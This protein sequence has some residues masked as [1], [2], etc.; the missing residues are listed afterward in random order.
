MSLSRKL[1]SPR[2]RRALRFSMIVLLFTVFL[3]AAC[4]TTPAADVEEETEAEAEPADTEEP[5]A[6]EPAE[7]PEAEEPAEEPEEEEPAAEEPEEE[8]EEAA[9]GE[10]VGP[11]VVSQLTFPS[12]EEW[13]RQLPREFEQVGIELDVQSIA[14]NA[15]IEQCIGQHECGTFTSTGSGVTDDRIDPNWFL[16][17]ILH[18]DAAEPGGSNLSQW[19]NPEVDAL[20][21]AQSVELDPAVR[22]EIISEIQEIFARET[23]FIPVYFINDVQAYNAE[24][25]ADV[26]ERPSAGILRPNNFTSYLNVRPLTDD[27]L[28]IVENNHDGNS[29]NPF[30]A[31]GGIFN[32]AT[33]LWVYDTLARMNDDLNVIPWA[34]E[35][36]EWVDD[37]TL[38]LTLRSDMQF[39]DG[40]PV[41]VDDVV[42]T[43]DYAKEHQFASWIPILDVVDSVEALDASTVQFNLSQPFAPFEA[44]VL[45]GFFIVPEHIWADVADPEA[46]ENAEP[47]GSGPWTFGHWRRNESWLFEINP[48]HWSPPQ[49]DVLWAIIPSPETW[50]GQFETGEIDANGTYIRGDSQIELV[51]EMPHMEVRTVPGIG[52]NNI[53][54]DTTELP[55]CDRDFRQAAH[56][57]VPKAR[58]LDAVAGK[59]GGV[60]AD[61]TFFHPETVWYNSEL[62]TYPYD[63]EAAREILEEAGYAWDDDGNLHYPPGLT[64]DSE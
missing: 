4:Q 18:S 28:L 5:A 59:G 32:T 14:A 52:V 15:W 29:T 38:E 17:Q 47:V 55:G 23:P 58:I 60:V 3:L 37:T 44:N 19:R 6:E 53:Y 8:A 35:S 62:P 1:S 54:I 2:P 21:E 26:L 22:Q 50:L 24:K 12:Y 13:W 64:C 56:H 20:I 41:T 51:E 43:F 49:V 30:V 39:H 7:E 9:M 42:F 46:F 57:L 27:T 36:W 11:L 10:A 25:Y 61:A 31:S 40:E 34:G 45:T 16:T 63:V 48:N 33:M